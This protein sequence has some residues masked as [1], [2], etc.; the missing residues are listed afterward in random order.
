MRRSSSC[1]RRSANA[2]VVSLSSWI[3]WTTR[4]SGT[5]VNAPGSGRQPQPGVPVHVHREGRIEAKRRQPLAVVHHGRA[6][7]RAAERE[8]RPAGPGAADRSADDEVGPRQHPLDHQV[9]RV[10]ALA[11]GGFLVVVGE[12]QQAVRRVLDGGETPCGVGRTIAIVLVRQGH[13][14]GGG[15]VQGERPVGRRAG[16]NRVDDEID[17]GGRDHPLQRDAR[18]RRRHDDR[19]GRP[20][21]RAATR[22]RPAGAGTRRRP[23]R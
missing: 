6:R 19:A 11:A 16:G 13:P 21:A 20:S 17:T 23:A 14:R 2:A 18:R 10:P 4:R 8:Q 12:H 5:S 22:D 3:R 15:L 1:R 7:N 9:E